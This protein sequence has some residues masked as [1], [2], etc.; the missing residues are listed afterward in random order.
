MNKPVEIDMDQIIVWGNFPV[1]RAKENQ[2]YTLKIDVAKYGYRS[3]YE[4]KTDVA[5]WAVE[6]DIDVEWTGY[7]ME[8]LN[9]RDVYYILSFNSNKLDDVTMLCLRWS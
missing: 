7:W 8:S 1:A 3:V 6:N 2:H 4:F 9:N 5:N